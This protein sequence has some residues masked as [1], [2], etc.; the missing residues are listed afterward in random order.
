VPSSIAKTVYDQIRAN[1]RVRRGQIGVAAQTITPLLADALQ[2]DRATGVILSDVAR[3]GPAEAAG[4]EV[5]DIVLA[6]NGKRME[7][8][9]QMRVNVYQQPIGSAIHLTVLR[10]GKNLEKT[11]A[12]LERENEL[13]RIDELIDSSGSAIRRLGVFLIP[14]EGPAYR[15]FDNP[16]R[17]RGAVVAG[18][19]P[20]LVTHATGLQ[21]GDIV[22]ALNGQP[23]AGPA[24]VER[25]LQKYQPGD[26]I[27]LQIERA[28]T[29]LFLAFEAE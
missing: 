6:L 29:L 25:L 27:A 13:S 18:R 3:S 11:V 8:A 7:N 19:I 12:V 23:V 15:L 28:G 10:G 17:L 21:N 1:G 5:G 4:L 20:S 24:D 14:L 16:R 2:L 22:Y 9:R 26:P